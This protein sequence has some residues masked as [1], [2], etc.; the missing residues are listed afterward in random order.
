VLGIGVNT[1]LSI[2]VLT[3]RPRLRMP[4]RRVLGPRAADRSWPGTL[5]TVGQLYVHRV[6]AN[7]TYQVVAGAVELLVFSMSSTI[8]SC[9]LPRRPP[10]R[11][12]PGEYRN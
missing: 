10:S 7:P 8:S 6:E 1:L 2:G 3:G 4:L 9:S 11:T 5:K 12:H